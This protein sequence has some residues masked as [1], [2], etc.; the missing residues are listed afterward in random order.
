[1]QA[2]PRLTGDGDGGDSRRSRQRPRCRISSRATEAQASQHRQTYKCEM[3]PTS[4]EPCDGRYTSSCRS[5]RQW[6]E[7]QSGYKEATPDGARRVVGV[8]SCIRICHSS[9][10]NSHPPFST[11]QP[12]GRLRPQLVSTIT[13]DERRVC[14]A[15]SPS[16]GCSVVL[17]STTHALILS[18]PMDVESR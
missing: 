18:P 1:M 17:A 9:K 4:C 6:K 2:R 16:D 12:H 11:R 3:A 13:R 10:P 14:W 5:H 7:G 15:L 8:D